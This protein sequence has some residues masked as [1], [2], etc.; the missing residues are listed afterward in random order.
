MVR[1]ALLA[2]LLVVGLSAAVTA[3]QWI[4]TGQ[5]ATGFAALF[6]NP[7]GSPCIMP[8]MLGLRPGE[9]TKAAALRL[10]AT[11]PATKR[12]QLSD[13]GRYIKLTGE[14]NVAIWFNDAQAVSTIDLTFSSKQR[15]TLATT[16]AALGIPDYIIVNTNGVNDTTSYYVAE[17]VI[18]TF[19]RHIDSVYGSGYREADGLRMN[20]DFIGMTFGLDI[21]PDS[22]MV[23]WAGFTT[24]S[25]YI[26]LKR[27]ATSGLYP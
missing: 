6:T 22:R 11:H 1:I 21:Q 10:L 9:T 8:C 23:K 4:G 7:D 20:G 24:V 25:R 14:M 27:V 12:L 26:E 13:L 15:P 5:P 19:V 17:K 18:L 3:A 16:V 2:A